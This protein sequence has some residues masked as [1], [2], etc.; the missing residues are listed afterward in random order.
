MKRMFCFL[1]LLAGSC[2]LLGGCGQTPA[3]SSAPPQSASS[4]EAV[5]APLSAFAQEEGYRLSHEERYTAY[6]AEHSS[7][8][9]QQVVTYVNIGLDRE[10]YTE[11][12]TISDPDDLLVLCN[13]YHK[14]PDGYEPADLVQ[15][16]GEHSNGGDVYKRQVQHEGMGG[17]HRQCH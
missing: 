1:F 11:V 15:I 17:Y 9:A 5:P 10:F 7:L 12:E 13:K 4:P 3:P 6:A 2:A 16:S 14:L 8:T